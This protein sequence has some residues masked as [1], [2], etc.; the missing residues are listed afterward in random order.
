MFPGSPQYAYYT[1]LRQGAAGICRLARISHQPGA[2]VDSVPLLRKK[3][4]RR[5]APALLALRQ[6]VA[7]VGEKCRLVILSDARSVGK[8]HNV[9]I[10]TGATLMDRDKGT[11]TFHASMLDA[12]EPPRRVDFS[13]EEVQRA[14][15]TDQLRVRAIDDQGVIMMMDVQLPRPL[16]PVKEP[17]PKK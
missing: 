4:C 15:G 8:D 6:A 13:Y 1:P 5:N 7:H 14:A 3:Q 11:T 16:P 10:G 9:E 2:V 12:L 17:Q